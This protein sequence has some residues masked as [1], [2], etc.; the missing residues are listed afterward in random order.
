MHDRQEDWL[1][2]LWNLPLEANLC[3]L[4][5]PS[6]S[7]K[8]RDTPPRRT[9]CLREASLPD[10]TRNFPSP[11]FFDLRVPDACHP[12]PLPLP[13]RLSPF[14]GPGS[15]SLP[16]N[17]ESRFSLHPRG[18]F[19]PCRPYPVSPSR[20]AGRRRGRQASTEDPSARAAQARIRTRSRASAS[21]RK[22]LANGAGSPAPRAPGPLADCG[23]LR[24]LA[25]SVE[26]IG[27][28]SRPI[29]NSVSFKY[30]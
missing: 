12:S 16:S 20:G 6:Q 17:R 8:S 15:G 3:H 18:K 14:P 21:R 25:K 29:K 13:F 24:G 1:P 10:V 9:A 27:L 26:R 30:L 22:A 19:R 4:A 11:G 28:K 7:A 23:A 5:P 2:P